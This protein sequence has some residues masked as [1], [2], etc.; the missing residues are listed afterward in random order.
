[1]KIF[2]YILSLIFIAG[3][4]SSCTDDDYTMLDG[5]E[6]APT[7]TVAGDT[8]LVLLSEN[9]DMEATS[10]SWNEVN[11]NV[12]TPVTYILQAAL[13]GTDFAAPATL[14]NSMDTSFSMT[15]A[16][17]NSRAI[18]MGILPETQG[19][20]DFRVVAR[21]GNTDSHDLISTP[22]TLTVTPYTDVLD[23]STDWGIVGSATPNGWD[24]PDI[25]FWQT[26]TENVF[27]AYANL[28]DGEIKFRQN[29]EW[30]VNYGGSGGNLVEGGDNILVTAGKYKV[31]IDFNNMTYVIEAF[32][33]GIVGDAAPNGWD[34][35]D[36][37]LIYDPT[38]DQFRAVVQF[39]DGEMKFRLN[40][41]WGVN[42]GDDGADGTLEAGG[43]NIPVTAGK[44]VVTVNVNEM[45]YE[46]EA[47]A[48][49]WGLV[50]DATPN[51]WDGPDV[52]LNIDYTSDYTS[53]GVWYINNVS[54]FAGEI[55]FRADNDWG[56]NY[57][58][59]GADGTLE[60]GGANIAIPADG[61][62]DVVMDLDNMTY[63]I[64]AN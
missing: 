44:Y 43:A 2:K 64:T 38:S 4:I 18:N 41:D 1:M 59:D 15:V 5:T 27:V 49:I 10:F 63:S 62:Y 11:L 37:P 56:L 13:G 35:P 21:F 17:L 36:V 57:G 52:Q 42:W 24:G 6:Q 29:N 51:G 60:N 48:N 31:T 16:Q 19:N 9:S 39:T 3:T 22:I 8:N 33:I 55:K 25:P 46:I 28:I 7:L 54:L 45:T 34:G 20:I 23:L 61:N 30:D 47:I 40:N 26:G 53:G 14:Q 58:D 12:N 32:S 50:G